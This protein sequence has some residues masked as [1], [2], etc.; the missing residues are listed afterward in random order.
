[1]HNYVSLA[2]TFVSTFIKEITYTN[3]VFHDNV[4]QSDQEKINVLKKCNIN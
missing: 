4:F 1:M 3:N 2:F